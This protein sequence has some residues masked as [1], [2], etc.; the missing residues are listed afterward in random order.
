MERRALRAHRHRRRRPRGRRLALARGPGPGA[1]GDR[2][3]RRGRARARRPRRPAPGRRRGRRDP[4]PRRRCRWSWSRTRSTPPPRSRWRPSSTRSA[5]ASRSR[6]RPPTGAAPAT[7]SIASRN[8]CRPPL[9][10]RARTGP[11][12]KGPPRFASPSSA[13][14]TS[15]SR[16]CVNAFLG[17]ERVIVSE[18]AGTTRDAIDT[19]LEFDGR[20][21]V[22]IDTAGI[23]RADQG[24][25]HGRLLRPAALRARRRARR[26]RARRL[27][28]RRGG[29]RR[30]PAG[31]RAGDEDRLRDAGRAQQVG[32]DRRLRSRGR[33]GAA[34]EADPPAP[35]GDHLLGDRRARRG[36]AARAGDRA[37]RPAGRADPDPGAEPL[38]RRGR[39]DHAAAAEA[40]QAPAPL[41]R[42]PGRHRAR[43][44]SRSRSTTGG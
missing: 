37:R 36:E 4:A 27:R 35:A 34:G 26:R 7:C 14:R 41:L 16:R 39:R 23:R 6:S 5:S 40:R 38:R 10:V 21:L 44:A 9:R 43:R 8:C 17:A 30:G 3:R 22:L 12:R 1:R 28:R 18:L 24:R 33:A 11:S 15:A 19:P 20:P 2:R 13:G 25:R 42:G 31:R 32:P 29:H